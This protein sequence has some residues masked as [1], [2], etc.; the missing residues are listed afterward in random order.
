MRKKV[1]IVACELPPLPGL[2]TR[3]GGLRIWGLGEGLKAH[4][5]DVRYALPKAAVPAGVELPVELAN[6]LYEPETLTETVLAAAPDA[7]IVEQWG[8]ATYLDDLKIPLAIDLHG[9]LSLENAFKEE[10]NFLSDA[11]TK[12]DA[13]A[14]ADLLICP[15][16]YQRQYFLSWFLLA[17]AAPRQAPTIVVPIGFPPTPPARREPENLRFVFGGV[18]WPWID[19]FPGLEILARRVAAHETAALD[20]FVG[21]PAMNYQHPLYAINK[22]IFRDYGER[23]ANLARVAFH[24]LT[25]REQ[26]LDVYAGASVAFDLYQPNPERQLAV[27]TRTVEYLWCGLP[28][29]YGDYGELAAPIRLY[30]AGWVVDPADEKAIGA[31]LDEIFGD[32]ASVRRKSA[33]A[34]RLAMERFAWDR[35]AAPL[36]R[37]LDSPTIR[38]KK[39]TLLAGFRDYFRKE[40]V[41]QILAA[42]EQVGKLNEALREAAVQAD[43]DRRERDKKHEDLS[44]EFKKFQ[45]EN[46]QRLSRQADLHREELGRKEDDLRRQQ[47]KLDREI[48][49]RD[50]ENE[51][52]RAEQK[53][54]VAEAYEEIARL[55]QD[56]EAQRLAHEEEVRG[57]VAVHDAAMAERR[58]EAERQSGLIEQL[59][60]ERDAVKATMAGRLAEIERAVADK[61]RYVETAE[62]R[63]GEMEAETATLRKRAALLERR[64]ADFE[65]DEKL[66]TRA[67]RRFRLVRLVAQAPR[68]AWLLAVNLGANIYMKIYEKR[69]GIKIFPGT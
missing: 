41:N 29:L 44:L 42:K 56:K 43:A 32:P 23:L 55:N 39:P 46:D 1:L 67:R 66:K 26:L 60:Q 3:G 49:K 15:G 65:D 7:V 59:A 51:R 61:E 47:E 64:L 58:A 13:L 35:A 25:P 38:E 36:A 12:I 2:P 18:T 50:A 69:K 17:G 14:K 62:R 16:E 63:L 11:L 21:A 40:S 20:L 33:N 52:L 27:T 28:P 37:F 31:A 10:S 30:D 24:D 48:E 4:G 57:L 6:L 45:Q 19:P 54:A 22:N 68:L 9:P 5:H 34:Q 8:L 53:S